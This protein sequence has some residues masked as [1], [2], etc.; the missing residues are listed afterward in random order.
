MFQNKDQATEWA[1]DQLKKY[2]IRQ[3][4]EYSIDELTAMNPEVPIQ[5]SQDHLKKKEENTNVSV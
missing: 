2:G 5:F 3:P 1:L 4:I